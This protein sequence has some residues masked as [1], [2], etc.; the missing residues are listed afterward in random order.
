M[1]S[2]PIFLFLVSL[3]LFQ[4]QPEASPPLLDSGPVS[5]ESGG[6]I[7]SGYAFNGRDV[8]VFRV[9]DLNHK[10]TGYMDYG[11][12]GEGNYETV[13]Y[14]LDESGKPWRV[15]FMGKDHLGYGIEW[16]Y[17]R[18]GELWKEEY[19]EGYEMRWVKWWKRRGS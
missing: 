5:Y 14:N 2:R 8:G 10:L 15:L 3:L 16:L 9:Y 1:S 7:R 18:E 6:V 19:R 11:R 17:T 4:C 13:E 12:P